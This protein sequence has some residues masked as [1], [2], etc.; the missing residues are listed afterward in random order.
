MSEKFEIE[1]TDYGWIGGMH[2]YGRINIPPS[3]QVEGY[4][5]RYYHELS[6]P[7]DGEAPKW[8]T[9]EDGSWTTIKFWTIRD[10][11]AAAKTWFLAD[12]RVKPGDK[13]VINKEDWQRRHKNV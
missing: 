12:P 1:V 8:W 5:P 10:V 9:K 2:F 3:R 4:S 7:S 6:R 11:I 13:L